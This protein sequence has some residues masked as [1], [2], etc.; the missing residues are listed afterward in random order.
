MK[1]IINSSINQDI[2]LI[3]TTD[4]YDSIAEIKAKFQSANGVSINVVEQDWHSFL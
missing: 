2:N 4:Y 1:I 3:T